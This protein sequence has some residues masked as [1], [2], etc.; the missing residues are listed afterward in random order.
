MTDTTDLAQDL[1][2]DAPLTLE[3]RQE[4]NRLRH[5]LAQAR[6]NLR[7]QAKLIALLESGRDDKLSFSIL[8]RPEFNREVA[9]MLA[10]DERYGGVSSLLYFVFGGLDELTARYGAVIADDTIRLIGDLLV[11]N[12]RRSDVLG[13]LGP[14][15]FGVMLMRCDNA[16]AW[17]KAEAMAATFNTALAEVKGCNLDLKISFG[18]YTFNET[19]DAAK[20]LKLA[21]EAVT[22]A[23]FTQ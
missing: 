1:L 10:F 4:W 19:D 18:A 8:T 17:R 16:N 11:K 2:A 12:I 20:G 21:A 13:R 15:E 6:L 7:A 23:R 5:E 14:D 3:Q 9:R 22:K